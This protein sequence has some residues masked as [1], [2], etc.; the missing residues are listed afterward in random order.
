MALGSAC[1]SKCLRRSDGW[2]DVCLIDRVLSHI[3]DRPLIGTAGWNDTRH[4]FQNNKYLQAPAVPNPIP[5]TKKQLQGPEC[6]NWIILFTLIW[7]HIYIL[8]GGSTHETCIKEK[9]FLMHYTS[10]SKHNYPH[11]WQ[12]GVFL[13]I[14]PA[15]N[16]ANG[17]WTPALLS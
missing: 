13:H 5:Y 1:S 9:K 2:S 16:K 12:R 6:F 14:P 10:K 3:R 7:I 11:L 8:V 4:L 15:A 17:H